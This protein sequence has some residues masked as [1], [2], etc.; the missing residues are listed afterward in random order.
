MKTQTQHDAQKMKT[1]EQSELTGVSGGVMPVYDEQG[2]IIRTCT[3]PV[4][5]LLTILGLIRLR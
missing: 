5:T 2:S 3:G 4:S 1:V